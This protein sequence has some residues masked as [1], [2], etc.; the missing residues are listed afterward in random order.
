MIIQLNFENGLFMK[1]SMKKPNN[2]IH[3]LNILVSYHGTSARKIKVMIFFPC[4]K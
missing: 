1:Y 3:I 4:G 2:F